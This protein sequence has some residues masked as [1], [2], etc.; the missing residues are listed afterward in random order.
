MQSNAK[1]TL[2]FPVCILAMHAATTAVQLLAA[3]VNQL[4]VTVAATVVA[5]LLAAAVNQLAA[6]VVAM[7]AVLLPAVVAK[8]LLVIQ[9]AAVERNVAC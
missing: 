2:C 8:R 7:A 6:M 1:S 3:A 9:V 5:L 4:A